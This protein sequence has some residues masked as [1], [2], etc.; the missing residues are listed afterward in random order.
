MI[1]VTALDA[2][3]IATFPPAAPPA[4]PADLPSSQPPC[5]GAFTHPVSRDR[6]WQIVS[7]IPGV[8]LRRARVDRGEA[9]REVRTLLEGGRQRLYLV[10]RSAAV[11][12]YLFTALV[13]LRCGGGGRDLVRL[14]LPVEL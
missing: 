8:W 11:P 12:V 7:G 13:C 6:G 5:S 3:P 4:A 1:G 9:E 2:K 14:R 10:R